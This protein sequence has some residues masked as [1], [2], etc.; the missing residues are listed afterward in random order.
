MAE[1]TP[2]HRVVYE[3]IR[4][5]IEENIY[6]GGSLLPSENE[7]CRLF[8]VTRPTVRQALARLENDGFIKRHQGKGSVVQ[9]IHH[10]L[11]ILSIKGVSQ[12]LGSRGSL[13]TRMIKKPSVGMWPENFMYGLTEEEK[14]VGCIRMERLRLLDNE[15]VIY[16]IVH[17]VNIDLS[18]F[19]QK[20]YE[21]R[22]LFSTLKNDYGINVIDGQQNIRAKNATEEIAGLLQVPTGK[23][24]LHLEVAHYT[25]KRTRIFSEAFCHTDRFYLYGSF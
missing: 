21:N 19:C 1:S 25:N 11:G 3:N 8:G 24:I 15:P 12:I 18:R 10:R 23:A 9:N 17:L 20:K 14:A 6:P 4:K 13:T 7:M 16:D 2:K 5:N 22:S